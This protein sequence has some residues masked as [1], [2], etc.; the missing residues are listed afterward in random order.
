M[1]TKWLAATCEGFTPPSETIN[2]TEITALGKQIWP[3][4]KIK[5]TS[6]ININDI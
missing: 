4:L 5:N 1:S 3:N 2:T 6:L